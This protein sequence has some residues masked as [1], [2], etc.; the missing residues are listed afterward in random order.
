M[1]VA[2]TAQA[3]STLPVIAHGV[4]AGGVRVAGLTEADAAARIEARLGPQ[5]RRD[6]VVHIAGRTFR[7]TGAQAGVRLNAARMA[8]QAIAVPAPAVATGGGTVVGTDIP[9]V[10]AHGHLAVAAFAGR[11]AAVAHR[12]P[13]A[14]SLVMTTAHMRIR[15]SRT[16][17]RS[18]PAAIAANVNSVLDDPSISRNVRAKVVRVAA[19]VTIDDLK[20]AYG[21]VVTVDRSTFTLRL[22]KRLRFVKKYGVAV[23]RAGLSTPAGRYH[24]QDRQIDPAWHVPNSAWAGSLAGSV[25]PGGA[26]NNPLKARWLGIA[27]G[28][29][30]HG[31][32]ED[33]SIGSA[34]SHGCI[35]MHVW[36]VKDLY[37]RV[38]VGA[39]VLIR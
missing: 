3:A 36:D 11:I 14:A 37:P 30:I 6:V 13:R 38:P 8:R 17:Y 29:G 12:S 22:F 16:G 24:I 9:V 26:P 31:T 7:L 32:A 1:L 19:G 5:V 4:T 27:D 18:D 28:V 39:T 15:G 2:P 25:I 10:I 20:R 35:R 23:G 34:A 33:W 21:T